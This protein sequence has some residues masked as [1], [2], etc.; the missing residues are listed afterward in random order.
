MRKGIFR[1]MAAAGLALIMLSSLSP[2]M[3]QAFCQVVVTV[4][5][6]SN[7]PGNPQAPKSESTTAGYAYK[8]RNN[9][10]SNLFYEF[11]GWNTRPDGTGTRHAPGVT[12][13][14]NAPLTL[15]AQWKAVPDA[16]LTVTY[17]ANTGDNQMDV[18]DL[19]LSGSSCTLK[20]G[21][22]VPFTRPL[23]LII[24]WNTRADGL[25]TQYTLGQVITPTW[26]LTLY[27]QWQ[28]F[29]PPT[30]AYK[31][32]YI[33]GPPDL[34]DMLYPF[35]T[36]TIRYNP[37]TREGYM[38][39]GWNTKPN[40][41]GNAIKEGQK[42]PV[43]NN[44]SLYAQWQKV[45]TYV[46]ITYKKNANDGQ[47]DVIDYLVQGSPYSVKNNPFTRVG[48]TFAGW[49]TKPNGTGN[50]VKEGKNVVVNGEYTLYA[51]WI[52][53]DAFVTITYKA[54]ANDGQ[55]DLIDAVIKGGSYVLRN[56][57]FT[58]PGYLFTGWN[59]RADGSGNA[60]KAGKLVT[61]NNNQVLYAQWSKSMP[62]TVTV[63]YK[64]NY[65]G[66]PSDVIDTVITG[67]SF[68]I[69]TAIPFTRPGY[70]FVGWSTSPDGIIM[71]NAGQVFT[72][73]ADMILYAIW[74]ADPVITQ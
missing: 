69:R 27:A 15:Y 33:G 14:V 46:T 1:K 16:V 74:R 28:H 44:Y 42:P 64:S 61:P 11:T 9:P 39:T 49:N 36:Y 53:I 58:R 3:G 31:A 60:G 2:S 5:Y 25:G 35:D 45:D 32:N 66:G 26:N 20:T 18:E 63:T 68:T 73:N 19:V 8:V 21:A 56:N 37:F 57:P 65:I 13:T 30:V 29:D 51:Q 62:A 48:Y 50:A 54:N 24:G 41:S 38:F 70:K 40:G 59:T 52:M 55:L 23:H 17:K 71:I 22:E 12:I 43:N 47:A 6:D 72:A 10:F 7:T 4:T 34:V 67:S